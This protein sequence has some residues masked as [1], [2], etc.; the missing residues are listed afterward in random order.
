M[1]RRI[2]LLLI[3]LLLPEIAFAA[4]AAFPTHIKNIQEVA[5]SWTWANNSGSGGADVDTSITAVNTAKTI[6]VVH[7]DDSGISSGTGTWALT[8]TSATNLRLH[9]AAGVAGGAVSLKCYLVEFYPNVIKSLQNITDASD[10]TTITS[11]DTDK[12]IVVMTSGITS[13]TSTNEAARARLT[14]AT[15]VDWQWDATFAGVSDYTAQV[16]EFK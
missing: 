4:Q 9:H 10:P 11:V 13:A 6:I 8:L 15:S 1:L 5:V 16:V 2:A 7:W 12:S 3:I 14:S